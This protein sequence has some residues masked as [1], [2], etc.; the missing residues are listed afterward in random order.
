MHGIKPRTS[1]PQEGCRPS[2]ASR[3]VLVIN[4]IWPC[5]D[6]GERA[7]NV[8]IY[9][10]VAELA[11]RPGLKLG[12]LKLD[13]A[14]TEAP[15]AA[16]RAGMRE[17]ASLDVEFLDPF[18]L[19]TEPRR[20][21]RLLRWLSPQEADFY[22]ETRLRGAAERAAMAF[23][24]DLVFIPWSEAATSLF[25][26]LRVA[27]FAYYGNPDPKSGL[28]RA[29]FAREHGGSLFDY[30]R[31]R[32]Q[33]AC[34]E[35]FHLKTMRRYEYLGDVA[36]NDAS[37]YQQ[38]GH[39]NAFYMRNLWIDRLGTAWRHARGRERIDPLVIVGNLGRLSATANTHGLEILGR[40]VLPQLRRALAGRAFEVH[41][42]GAGTPHPAVA[43]LLAAP[44]I[45]VRGFVDDIDG[46]LMTAPV[47]LCLNNASRFKVCHTRYLHAWSLGGCAVGHRDAALSMPEMVSG[48][49]CLLGATPAEIADM[50]GAVA[51]DGALRRRLGAAGY[52]TF[53]EKFTARAVVDQMLARFATAAVAHVGSDSRKHQA[54]VLLS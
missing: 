3:R 52:E 53:L 21:S 48:E 6:H 29:A 18:V 16:E 35:R 22:P 51:Q 30:A 2:M 19:A 10:L 49:N 11:R 13:S 47:F 17:L 26:D 14:P 45:R 44:E 46:E 36:A 7:A 23:R 50:V 28:A 15:T 25:A 32:W 37:Y 5:A 39:P 1:D 41:V 43:R 27:K 12:F 34:L 24:P 4:P 33:L 38:R 42:F 40:D 54:T 9:E 31:E 8:V 20:R